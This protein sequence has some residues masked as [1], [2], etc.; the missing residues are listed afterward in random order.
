LRNI[1][2]LRHFCKPA[3]LATVLTLP[4]HALA[5]LLIRDAWVRA[6]PPTQRMTAGYATVENIGEG[7]LTITGAGSPIAA[8]AELH[9]TIESNGTTRMTPL[10]PI[11]LEPGESFTFAPGGP[12]VM[13]MG[14]NPMPAPGNTV[15]LC[16]AAG[17]S[18]TC[19]EVPVSR[20][21]P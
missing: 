14:V 20:S 9:T 2:T 3:L 18:K 5:D 11:T 1:M 15:E 4:A 7:A 16:F 19:A 12:H 17:E 10:A 21:A 6:M 8:I 13:L